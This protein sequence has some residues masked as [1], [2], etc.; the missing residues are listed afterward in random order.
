VIDPTAL[1]LPAGRKTAKPARPGG[2]RQR[3][4]RVVDSDARA[5]GQEQAETEIDWTE[6]VPDW[7][8]VRT[9]HLRGYMAFLLDHYSKTY[10]NNQYRALQQFWSWWADEEDLPNPMAGM[11]P[12]KPGKRVI[13]VLTDDEMTSLIQDAERGRDF[14][15]RRDVAILRFFACTGCRREE[16]ASLEVDRLDLRER[17]T[18]VIGKGDKE[19]IV[20]FDH[21]CARAIDRYLRLRARHTHAD[22]TLLWLGVNNRPPMTADGVYQMVARRA[23][24]LGIHM[25]PHKF[26]HTFSHNW[27]DRGGAPG[28]LKQLNGWDSDAMVGHYGASAAASRAARHYDQVNVMGGI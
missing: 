23:K 6:P 11:K 22:S 14:Q 15:S 12:P 13:P 3:P 4:L 21:A 9:I 26:R 16:T 18:P 28:D 2:P 1:Y 7:S 20:H 27:L 25:F 24:R 8:L 10:A 19:R 5:G 17:E